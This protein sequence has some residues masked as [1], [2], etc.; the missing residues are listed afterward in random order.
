MKLL[1]KLDV[2]YHLNRIV[3]SP[4]NTINP[5]LLYSYSLNEGSMVVFDT[6]TK[7]KINVIK[8]HNT[9]ILKIAINYTGSMAATCS[10]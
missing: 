10:T 4:N 7:E 5:F 3:L 8:C 6:H 2:E 1:A 9:P